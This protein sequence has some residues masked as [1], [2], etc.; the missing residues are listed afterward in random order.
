MTTLKNLIELCDNAD[1]CTVNIDINV[2]SDDVLK[3]TKDFSGDSSEDFSGDSSEEEFQDKEIIPLFDNNTGYHGF[4]NPYGSIVLAARASTSNHIIRLYNNNYKYKVGTKKNSDFV[5]GMNDGQAIFVES[6]SKVING[7]SNRWIQRI[8]NYHTV[9]SES[10]KNDI[11][12]E[13]HFNEN[14]N[15]V[16]DTRKYDY[17]NNFIW[18]PPK[19]VLMMM[20][21]KNNISHNDKTYSLFNGSPLWVCFRINRLYKYFVVKLDLDVDELDELYLHVVYEKYHN[22]IHVNFNKE[23]SVYNIKLYGNNGLYNKD[24]NQMKIEFEYLHKL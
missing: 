22:N 9:T 13:Q 4:G 21:D 2:N 7:S 19:T 24:T 1:T 8:T 15:K 20:I 16:Y 18:L 23:K 10:I 11:G 17:W 6:K 14:N 5:N 3:S 12:I